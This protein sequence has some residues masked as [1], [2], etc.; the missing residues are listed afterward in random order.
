MKIGN[1]RPCIYSKLLYSVYIIMIYLRAKELIILLLGDVLLLYTALF[2]ALF[3]RYFE[4]PSATLFYTHAVPFSFLFLVSV[5]VFFISGLYDKQ[6][7]LLKNRLPGLIAYAQVVNSALA[8]LFFFFVPS[9]GIQPKTNLILYLVISVFFV[10]VWRLFVSPK[11]TSAKRFKALLVGEGAEVEELIAE[12][13]ANSR[14][15]FEFV[16]ALDP[17][18]MPDVLA[19]A[20]HL[21]EFMARER[22]S[23]VVAD[24]RSKDIT[25]LLSILYG[26]SSI[27]F[28]SGFIDLYKVY[29]EIFDRT[30]LSVLEYDWFLEHIPQEGKPVYG[31]LKRVLDLVGGVILGVLAIV[32]LPFVWIALRLEDKGGVFITQ[33]R[34]G[35]HGEKIRVYKFRTMKDN[36]GRSGVW[37]GESRNVVTKVG[38]ILRHLS[39]DEWPQAWNIIKGEMSLIGPRNDILGIAE[40]LSQE[41]PYYSVRYMVKPGIT[42]WAQT[43]QIY[44]SGNISPQSVEE[45]RLRLAYDIFYVKNRSILLDLNIALRTMGT[46]LSRFGVRFF[47]R[48]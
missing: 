15:N 33:E 35:K 37:I 48:K 6:T 21:E 4:L 25:P 26:S 23:I 20:Q 5:T 47:A 24:A 45:S 12:V 46:L 41:I 44:A 1:N 3:L 17:T 29:E 9:F 2:G 32:V 36:E 10:S 27:N 31:I 42:G 7:M 11:L 38:S 22:I 39:V 16:R 40:R 43:H 13:N 14:Y 28:R 34:V 18:N 19:Q 8:V 30:P